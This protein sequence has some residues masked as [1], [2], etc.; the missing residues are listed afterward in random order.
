M[1]TTNDDM[2]AGVQRDNG[3]DV[4]A[5]REASRQGRAAVRQEA[6]NL[7]AAVENLLR[8]VKDAA[9]PEIARVRVEAES[10]VAATK[11]ALAGRAVQ[12]RRTLEAGDRYVHERPWPVIGVAA[13]AGLVVGLLIARR[14]MGE[15]S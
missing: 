11:R 14:G 8:C 7:I 1:A 15:Q 4:E 10:A 13:M 2:V 9:D 6:R 3:P 5:A 12:V